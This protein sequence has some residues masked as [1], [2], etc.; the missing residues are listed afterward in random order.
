[1]LVFCTAVMAQASLLLTDEH[2]C[3]DWAS[4]TG[5]EGSF[6]HV[7]EAYGALGWQAEARERSAQWKI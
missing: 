2:E 3:Y 4:M 7:H 5:A 1:M 6:C